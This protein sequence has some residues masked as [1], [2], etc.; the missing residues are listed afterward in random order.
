MKNRKIAVTPCT[1][2][3]TK[4]I[5][6]SLNDASNIRAINTSIPALVVMSSSELLERVYQELRATQ[7]VSSDTLAKIELWRNNRLRSCNAQHQ[8]ECSDCVVA[9]C[10]FRT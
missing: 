4:I 1:P 9:K 7:T 10:P 5:E 8:E 3:E 6:D 2:S